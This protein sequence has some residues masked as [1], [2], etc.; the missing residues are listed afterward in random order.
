MSLPVL[1]VF[2]PSLSCFVLHGSEDS[3]RART[4]GGPPLLVVKPRN[5]R[6]RLR[7]SSRRTFT[8]CVHK[9]KPC[10]RELPVSWITPGKCASYRKDQPGR[11]SE[12]LGGKRPRPA[13]VD[14]P[15]PKLC[16]NIASLNFGGGPASLARGGRVLGFASARTLRVR[17]KALRAFFVPGKPTSN[18]LSSLKTGLNAH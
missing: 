10:S 4:R 9:V 18:S 16:P 3:A 13:R 12:K 17:K 15:G 14:T 2:L 5:R 8:S 1:P 11:L 6:Y 7:H